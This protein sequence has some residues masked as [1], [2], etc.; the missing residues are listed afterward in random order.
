MLQN[1]LEMPLDLIVKPSK[2]FNL[3]LLVVFTFSFIG[4]FISSLSV[5]T[6]LFFC[7]SLLFCISFIIKK[8]NSNKII[9][10][11][12]SRKDK[13]KIELNTHECFDVELEGECI[14]TFFLVWLN[15]STYNSL[16]RKKIFHLLLLPDSTDEDSIRRLR[17]RLRLLSL[18]NKKTSVLEVD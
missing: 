9:S 1:K 5:V 16:G 8:Q 11:K 2:I 17:V 4:I 6:Q 10:L 7:I 13:W 14:V 3:Y 18:N 12:L 15:F